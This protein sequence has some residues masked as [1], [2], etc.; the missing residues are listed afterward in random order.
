MSDQSST[1]DLLR[2]VAAGDTSSANILV[3]RYRKRL[4]A[5]VHARM[6]K[7]LQGRFDASDVVQDAL[8]EAHRR[9]ADYAQTQPIAFYPWLRQLTFDRL[10][11][12]HRR[13]LT[14]A[15][16]SVEREMP[17]TSSQALV[18]FLADSRYSPLKDVLREEMR[19]RIQAALDDI[20]ASAQEV[21][22]LRF[23]EQLSVQE[24]SEVLGVTESALKSRQLRALKVLSQH[25][26]L[27]FKK[28][29]D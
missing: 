12:L 28:T 3:E 18:T 19:D 16:R 2:E 1:A 4:K 27:D 6:D 14:A 5:M 15:K 26:S 9:L 11:D 17:D 25:L 29:D 23:V 20:P 22:M 13:H 21:L 8:V 24:A 7:R 10:V